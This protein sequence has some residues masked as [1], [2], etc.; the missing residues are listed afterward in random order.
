MFDDPEDYGTKENFVQNYNTMKQALE[1]A[2]Q[3]LKDCCKSHPKDLADI[4]I[5]SFLDDGPCHYLTIVPRPKK[6]PVDVASGFA[7]GVT[8]GIPA[9]G[10][11]GPLDHEIY[12]DNG[13]GTYSVTLQ[14]YEPILTHEFQHHG[15]CCKPTEQQPPVEFPSTKEGLRLK[16]LFKNPSEKSAT[17]AENKLRCYCTE[18][19]LPIRSRYA[20]PPPGS[21]FQ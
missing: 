4:S 15:D 13:D 12:T 21:I 18:L 3:K 17:D 9:Q 10:P 6:G 11:A 8:L 14:T 2:L 16:D 1:K 5:C 7:A 20:E 19:K